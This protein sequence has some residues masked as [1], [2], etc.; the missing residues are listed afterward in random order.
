MI[1]VF[2]NGNKTFYAVTETGSISAAVEE[3]IRYKKDSMRNALR[4]SVD[5]GRIIETK[6]EYELWKHED[7]KD[8]FGEIC[9]IVTKE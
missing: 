7:V 2:K 6:D 8:K 4:Y 1:K 5:I 3:V 9:W